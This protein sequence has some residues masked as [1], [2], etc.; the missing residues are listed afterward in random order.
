MLKI[1]PYFLILVRLKSTQLNLFEWM[2]NLF[3]SGQLVLLIGFKQVI[4]F[5][6]N[7]KFSSDSMCRNES[8]SMFLIPIESRLRWT[9]EVKWIP[10]MLLMIGVWLNWF[11]LITIRS[12][13]EQEAFS[14]DIKI[15]KS[16]GV[17][18]KD[19]YFWYT[20]AIRFGLRV[21]RF[22]WKNVLQITTFP[23]LLDVS[24]SL[25]YH[26]MEKFYIIM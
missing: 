18:N 7:Y 2:L 12:I 14:I 26:F 21:G 23:R 5:L 22:F 15:S 10:E 6:S 16:Y 9:R 17:S 20:K 8:P 1:C 25:P 13:F 11:L 3:S 19:H 4:K 24:E